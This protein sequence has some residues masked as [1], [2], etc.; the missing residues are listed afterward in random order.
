MADARNAALVALE[1]CRRA[2]AWSDAVLGSV[3]DREG[4][5]GRDRAFAT[6]LCYGVLQNL[7]LL[8]HLIESVSSVPFRR[9]E[10]KVLDILRLSAYQI[11]LLDRVPAA[12]AV[13]EGVRLCRS[14]GVPRAAGFVNAVLRKIA[15]GAAELP[16]GSSPEALSLR[17]S[18]P[19]WLVELYIARLG[20]EETEALLQIQNSAAPVTLQVNT[21]RT[22]TAILCSD[23]QSAGLDAVPHPYLADCLLLQRGGNLRRLTAFRNGL[24]YVQDAAAKMAV[25]AADPKPG[26]K[27]LDVC[28]APGGKSFAAAILGKDVSILSCDIHENKLRRIREG[29]ERLGITQITAAAYDARSFQPEMEAGFDL[30]I[31]DVPCSGLGVIRKKPDIRYKD[32]ADFSRF[33]EIQRAIL[34]NVSRYVALGGILLYST[35]TVRRE[36]NEDVVTAFLEGNAEFA[37]E[38]FELPHIGRVSNGMMQ[39]WPHR[40][41]T[42]GFFIAKLRRSN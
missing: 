20:A 29:S 5:D 35:C 26:M 36:E 8:D 9:I 10:P 15:G 42:D 30:V 23:L 31:A 24:F 11:L 32:P 33:P 3:M 19:L 14:C 28:A 21:L 6:V 2:D 4:L 40:H 18:H 34:Q 27:I 1:K 37:A 22:E 12:A 38:G 25:I 13:S 16:A 7:L 41:E 17:F 39:L